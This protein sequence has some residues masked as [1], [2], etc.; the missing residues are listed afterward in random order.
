M[1]RPKTFILGIIVGLICLFGS[2]YFAKAQSLKG[3]TILLV[4]DSF[5]EGINPWLQKK[6]K[7]AGAH[8]CQ[9]YKRGTRLEYWAG[10]RLDRALR[11]C[12]PDIVFVSLGA[13]H[14]DDKHPEREMVNI[15]LIEMQVL[16]NPTTRKVA[17]LYFFGP[18]SWKKSTGIEDVIKS[19]VPNY[20]DGRGVKVKRQ[21]DKKH[22]T[23]KSFGKLTDLFWGWFII[24]YGTNR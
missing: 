3:K 4:G 5:G 1:N 24:N 16:F 14:L 11:Q 18:D 9:S 10:H 23:M 2:C 22:P 20:W 13:N 15:I 8:Y 7:A 17:Q 19:L 21:P 12:K 6:V